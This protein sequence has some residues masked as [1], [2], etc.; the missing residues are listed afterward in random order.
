[1]KMKDWRELKKELL[2][3]PVVAKEYKKLAPEYALISQMIS[4]RAKK[5]ITQKELGK[6][7]NYS[8]M[9]ISHFENGIRELK[10][11]DIQKLSGYFEK[12]MSFFLQSETVFFRANSTPDANIDKALKDFNAYLDEVGR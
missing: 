4:I 12:D 2:K 11:S 3:D 6:I 5:R 10:V 9:G 1:M 7:L 8:P